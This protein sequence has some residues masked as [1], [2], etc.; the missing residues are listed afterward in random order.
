MSKLQNLVVSEVS[1]LYTVIFYG[2]CLVVVYLVTATRRTSDAR[3]WLYF[4]LSVNFILERFVCDS[5]LP[6]ADVTSDKLPETIYFRMWL[7]RKLTL[8]ACFLV[9]GY[10]AYTFVDY[11]KVN[12][13]LLEDI[14]R[15]N[16]DLKHKMEMVQ[17][18]SKSHKEDP[19]RNRLDLIDGMKDVMVVS[20]SGVVADDD[21][22]SSDDDTCSFNSTQTDRTWLATADQEKFPSD[23]SSTEDEI[24]DTEVN[25][26]SAINSRQSSP[27]RVGGQ[28]PF[29]Y[30]QEAIVNVLSSTPSSISRKQRERS[31]TPSASVTHRYNLRAR[32]KN[33]EENPVLSLESP[34]TF[35]N[36]VSR[37]RKVSQ[38]Q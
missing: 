19:P 1:W 36:E 37:M 12:N 17:L 31:A 30:A 7:C 27:K 14:Y 33:V 24:T 38:V 25:F 4:L 23:G 2:V 29:Y 34:N 26:V 13:K 5:S 28:E 8:T 21:D 35:A 32:K 15:Q 18:T 6:D 22:S 10:F 16:A 3:L 20:D 9:T 11:D